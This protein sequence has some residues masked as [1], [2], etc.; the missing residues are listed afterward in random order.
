MAG[1]IGRGR[2]WLSKIENADVEAMSVADYLML[3]SRLEGMNSKHPAIALMNH[4]RQRRP[5]FRV[6]KQQ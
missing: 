1:Q 3:V 6:V 2:S 4:L 5:R